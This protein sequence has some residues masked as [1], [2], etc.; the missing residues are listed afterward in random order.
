MSND[1]RKPDYSKTIDYSKKPEL[2]ETKHNYL[3]KRIESQDKRQE[4]SY[5]YEKKP[6]SSS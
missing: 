6:Y 1:I 2:V 5:G 4:L 3:D